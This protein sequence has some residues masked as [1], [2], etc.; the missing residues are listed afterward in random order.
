MNKPY[1]IV[2]DD[3]ADQRELLGLRLRREGFAVD[4]V[5]DG[6][7]LLELLERRAAGQGP[8]RVS[9]VISDL[10]MPE[11]TGWEVLE[12]M[13]RRRLEVPVLIVS[14]VGD[15]LSYAQALALGARAVLT[16]PSDWGELR[17]AVFGAL[18][19]AA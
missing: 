14:A 3:D 10:M 17:A 19:D 8:G 11:C 5:A 1:V 18:E 4:T 13:R 16:K 2:A 9:L 15:L 6:K 7:E 12:A